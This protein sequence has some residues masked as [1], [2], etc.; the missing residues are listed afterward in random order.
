M[1][2]SLRAKISPQTNKP[3]LTRSSSLEDVGISISATSS[4]MKNG[5]K[6]SSISDSSIN[7]YH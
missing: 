2:G 1:A 7:A 5:M 4:N 3:M 6:I